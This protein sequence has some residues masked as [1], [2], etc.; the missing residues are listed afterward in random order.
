MRPL[1]A[2]LA[3]LVLA[4]CAQQSGKPIDTAQV[5][6][7]QKGVT[8]YDQVLK[9]MGPPQSYSITNGVRT[10]SYGASRTSIAA[11]TQQIVGFATGGSST[12]VQQQVAT[13]TFGP[14]L[15]LKDMSMS[16]SQ[17]TTVCSG[18]LATNCA[19]TTTDPQPAH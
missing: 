13:F 12:D 18:P 7:F 16:S 14:D 15:I 2:L 5:G 1:A 19:T 4:G 9:A 3:A 17:G 11:S 10:I 6:T 8:T